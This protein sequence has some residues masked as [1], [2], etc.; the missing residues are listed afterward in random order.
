MHLQ[1]KAVRIEI[2]EGFDACRGR[3]GGEIRSGQAIYPEPRRRAGKEARK[4]SLQK[5][6]KGEGGQI[7]NRL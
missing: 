5:F 3:R 1:P 7:A 4:K 6:V 2:K